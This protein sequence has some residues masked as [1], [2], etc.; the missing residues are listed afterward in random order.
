MMA[1]IG[2]MMGLLL[3]FSLNMFV[4]FMFNLVAE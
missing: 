3:G 4:N 1:E 2:G